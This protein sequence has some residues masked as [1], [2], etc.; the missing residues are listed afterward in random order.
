MRPRASQH[1]RVDVLA[2]V[3][4]DRVHERAG[5]SLEESDGGF[6]REVVGVVQVDHVR[7]EP[8]ER[9]LND[10]AVD[11]RAGLDKV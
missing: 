8:S 5:P 3:V 11:F 10:R 7:S 4:V 9:A 1:A 6:G 2:D